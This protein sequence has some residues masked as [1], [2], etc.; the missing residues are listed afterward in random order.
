MYS[1]KTGHCT[2]AVVVVLLVSGVTEAASCLP[3]ASSG[4]GVPRYLCDKK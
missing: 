3:A 4:L 1:E 2:E